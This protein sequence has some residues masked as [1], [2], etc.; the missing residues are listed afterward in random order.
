MSAHPRS[1][2]QPSLKIAPLATSSLPLGSALLGALML[3]GA[4]MLARRHASSGAGC[5][6]LS[7]APPIA[8]R[9]AARSSATTP[10]AASLAVCD[11]LLGRRTVNQFARAL[12]EG[13]ESALETA[14]TCAVHAPNHRRT[15]PWRFH[16]LG[17]EAARRVC[18]L[19]AELVAA[20]KGEAAARK[21]L[22]RWLAMPGWLVV[23]CVGS[24]EGLDDA[25]NSRAREDYA[26]VCCAVQNLC[27]ALHAG[28]IGTKW[29]T[30]GVN[31]DPRFNEAAGVPEDEYVVGTIWF[32]EAAGKPPLRPVKRLGLDAVLTRH[33]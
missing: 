31:F 17:P 10:Q 6:A 25:P 21:K 33:D 16:L 12:P 11:A 3:A 4:A 20:S 24:G 1:G 14:L 5:R 30:G 2:A 7:S 29:S 15:E 8:R 32:G 27:V 18:E 9:S 28:G 19:N 13:W 22:E 23:T 26:A